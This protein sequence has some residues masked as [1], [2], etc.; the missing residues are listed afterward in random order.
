M[1]V[2]IGQVTFDVTTFSPGTKHRCDA[3]CHPGDCPPCP[4]ETKKRCR[5]GANTLTVNCV[6]L[7]G[8]Q[9]EKRCNLLLDENF[10]ALKLLKPLV[11]CVGCKGI[12]IWLL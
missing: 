3:Q 6:D 11:I 1:R 10:N 9:S 8:K 5:C 7:D 2:C 12:F 4:L